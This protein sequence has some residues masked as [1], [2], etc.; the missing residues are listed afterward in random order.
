MNDDLLK[1]PAFKKTLEA[2]GKTEVGQKSRNYA[3]KKLSDLGIDK[4]EMAVMGALIKAA[5]D[6]QLEYEFNHKNFRFRPR[7]GKDDVGL[8]I[9]F[10][11]DF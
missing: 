2:L 6:K 9:H 3:N 5:R 1:E 4:K 11:T 7:V 10:S 8:G